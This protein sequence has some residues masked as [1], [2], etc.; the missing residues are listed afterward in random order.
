MIIEFLKEIRPILKLLIL[1]EYRCQTDDVA[2][3]GLLH[4]EF[5]LLIQ[6]AP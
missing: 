2:L 4:H 5:E 3:F 1:F 6:I